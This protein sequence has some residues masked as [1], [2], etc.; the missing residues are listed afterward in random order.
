MVTMHPPL[1]WSFPSLTR[2]WCEVWQYDKSANTLFS[3]S[4][5]QLSIKIYIS[6]F[7]LFWFP[8]KNSF[9]KS[10][11]PIKFRNFF[12]QNLDLRVVV[13]SDEQSKKVKNCCIF[14]VG[15]P[16]RWETIAEI[17]ERLPS[18]VPKMAKKIK[19]NAFM[20]PNN[21]SQGMIWSTYSSFS[22][23]KGSPC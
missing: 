15:K 22:T 23:I 1:W 10:K 20:V 16:N 12:L 19:D 9:S 4:K 5:Q 7:C 3:S 13:L 18:E 6:I 21:T 8:N 17:L 14:V 2:L 11:K